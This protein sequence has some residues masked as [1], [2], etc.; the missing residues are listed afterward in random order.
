MSNEEGTYLGA[1]GY[2]IYKESLTI[3]EQILIR[4]ELTVKANVPKNLGIKSEAFP[5]YRESK[6]KFYIPRYYGID[7]YGYP[8]EVKIGMGEEI[9]IKFNG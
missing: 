1:K 8:N 2:T 5:I 4:E 3:E 9:N 6:N 7:E